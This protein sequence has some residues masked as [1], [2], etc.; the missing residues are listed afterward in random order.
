MARL[1]AFIS[2]LS[3]QALTVNGQ[4]R[5]FDSLR[6]ALQTSSADTARVDIL[7]R[8]SHA[9]YDYDSREGFR[10]AGEA[11]SLASTLDYLRGQRHALT[12]M[13]FY[14]NTIGNYREA[15][16]YYDRSSA[17]NLPEDDLLGYNFVMKA[18]V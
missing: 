4:H 6:Q 18:N 15:L 2:L 3:F 9:Y 5:A 17:V 12:L 13:G 16:R 10:Y 14:Y 11:L 7:N 1:I 8:L